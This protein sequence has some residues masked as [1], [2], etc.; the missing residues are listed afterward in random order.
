VNA[1]LAA[2]EKAVTAAFLA[3]EKAIVKAE[4]AQKDYND[5]SNEFRGQLDDQAKTLMARTETLTMFKSVDEKIV[6]VIDRHDSDLSTV[7]SN[8][9]EFR[10]FRSASGA[11]ED[12]SYRA[13]ERKQ[14]S[15]G[16]IVAVLFGALMFLIAAADLMVRISKP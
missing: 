12:A 15:A 4:I 8:I 13:Q 14:W 5:R 6:S 16:T 3:S 2:Q 10:E 1:A 11:T 7:R 9:N